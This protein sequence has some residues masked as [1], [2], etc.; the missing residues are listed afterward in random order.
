MGNLFL[1]GKKMAGCGCTELISYFNSI[2]FYGVILDTQRY[3]IIV[4]TCYS[5]Y[6]KKKNLIQ[7]RDMS[8]FLK[9]LIAFHSH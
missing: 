7:Q 9:C 2:S 1:P 4:G 6:R 3:I 5:L 8:N